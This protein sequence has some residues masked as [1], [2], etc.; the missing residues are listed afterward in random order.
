MQGR[1]VQMP[2]QTSVQI[3]PAARCLLADDARLYWRASGEH[4][5]D[6]DAI[7]RFNTIYPEDWSIHQH[8]ASA[9]VDGRVHSLIE[10]RHGDQ[11]FRAHTLWRFDGAGRVVQA[12][13]TLATVEPPPS[14][15]TDEAIGAHRRDRLDRP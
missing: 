9:L 7:I 2:A 6:A 1:P 4:L 3:W 11:R 10:L 12:D 13:E 8:D 15:R 5:L 14:W